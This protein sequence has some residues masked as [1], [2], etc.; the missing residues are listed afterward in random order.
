[1]EFIMANFE[2]VKVID[3]ANTES[4]KIFVSTIENPYKNDGTKVASI[5][6]S[7]NGNQDEI[8]WKVHIP[9]S[10]ISDVVDA[11]KSI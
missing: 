2:V 8:N 11:L 9:I 10:N 4:G 6:I 1:M 3:L 7:L 5:G